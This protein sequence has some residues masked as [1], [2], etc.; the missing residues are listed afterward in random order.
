M[1][2]EA[3]SHQALEMPEELSG[4]L[5]RKAELIADDSYFLI[6]VV[7][8]FV[9]GGAI[10]C[11]WWASAAIKQFHQRAVLRSDGRQIVGRVTG[12]PTGRG[13]EYVKYSFALNGRDF[14][15]KARIPLH[16]GIGLHEQD[17]IVIRFLPS[18]PTINYP[19]AWEWSPLMGLD[20]IGFQIFCAA[21][22][23]LALFFLRRE[24]RLAC[25]GKAVLGVVTSCEPKDRQFRVNYDFRTD[26][27]VLIKGGSGCKYAY[28]SGARIWILYLPS[29]PNRNGSYPLSDYRVTAREA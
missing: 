11:G 23:C 5:P 15:G 17:Q 2:L 1:D 18:D 29:R 10:T 28:K 24:R 21:I 16:A 13:T 27:G 19:D 26:D 8:I 9:V 7:L 6:V 3:P 12:L 20:A 4:P 22:V 14:S 25:E